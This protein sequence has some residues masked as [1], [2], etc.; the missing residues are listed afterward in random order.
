MGELYWRG[1]RFGAIPE[2]SDRRSKQRRRAI[3]IALIVL[4]GAA[5]VS[6]V[7]LLVRAQDIRSAAALAQVAP[8]RAPEARS[9]T[10]PGP[11]YILPSD[12][13]ALVQDPAIRDFIGLSENSRD[14]TAP[15]DIPGFGR[16]P[17][18]FPDEEA[19]R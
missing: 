10:V 8:D 11:R 7:A 12:I 18:M 3:K 19:G 5:A 2:E 15:D 1:G 13:R 6:S 4:I 16:I 17:G 14:F 9:P